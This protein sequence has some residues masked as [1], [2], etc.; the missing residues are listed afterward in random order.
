[1]RFELGHL[2]MSRSLVGEKKGHS[3]QK[4]KHIDKDIV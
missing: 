3:G 2:K 4:E 1:M